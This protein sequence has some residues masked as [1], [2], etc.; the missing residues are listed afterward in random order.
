MSGKRA[1]FLDLDGTLVRDFQDGD[2]RRGP[3]NVS[4]LDIPEGTD[5]AIEQLRD[6]FQR[7]VVTNQ[8]DIDRGL[9]ARD[10]YTGVK[11]TLM[12][13][14]RLALF[15][16]C[17]HQGDWCAC[18]KPKPGM[19]YQAAILRGLD[20]ARCWLIGDRDSDVHAALAAGIPQSQ[21]I[22]IPTNQGIAAAVRHILEHDHET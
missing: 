20:L 8:P 12:D 17:P 3:R 21:A 11:F 16:I 15:L 1:C 7:I 14:W 10:E 19:I 22:L 2:V 13:R 9:M 18:R 4:E 6:R 5:E